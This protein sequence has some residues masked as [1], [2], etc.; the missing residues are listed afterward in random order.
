MV[1]PLTK[2]GETIPQSGRGLDPFRLDLA[3]K[4]ERK[5]AAVSLETADGTALHFDSSYCT[6]NQGDDGFWGGS[7]PLRWPSGGGQRSMSSIFK[8]LNR[9]QKG[10][11]KIVSFV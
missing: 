6:T 2:R 5:K 9:D 1:R 10:C 11:R 7:A 4:G 8:N 3:E